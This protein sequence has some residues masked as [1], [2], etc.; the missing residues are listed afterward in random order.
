MFYFLLQT[1][2]FTIPLQTPAYYLLDV[3]LNLFW[4]E[5]VTDKCE[6]Q[7]TEQEAIKHVI[8]VNSQRIPLH[9]WKAT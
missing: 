5:Q 6:Q 9:S 4:E 1:R 2:R 3:T 8:L 7:F